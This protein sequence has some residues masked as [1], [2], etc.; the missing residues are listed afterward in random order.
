MASLTTRISDMLTAVSTSVRALRTL[1][2]GSATGNLT[3]LTTTDKTSIIAAINEVKAG[4]GGGASN[5]D[6]LT[7]VVI[8]SAATGDILRFNG[9]NWV[10]VD[11]STIFDLVGAAAAAQAASQPLDADL[12]AIAALTT[13]TYGRAILALANQAALMA[14][15]SNG[16]SGAPGI[17]QLASTAQVQTGTDTAL[18]TTSAGVKA[19]IDQRIDN[20][21]SLGASTTNAPSQAAVKAYA[22]ALIAANDAFTAKGGINASANPNFPA[23][24][25]GDTY[26]ITNAGKIGGASGDNVEVGDLVQCWVDGSAAGTKATVGANWSIIQVNIDGAV[27]GPASSV[28]ANLAAFNGTSGKAVQD[29]GFSP[30]NAAIGAGSATILPTSA[31]I[32]AFSQPKDAT[33]TALAA[34]VTATDTLI[35]ATGVDTFATTAFTAFAR[36]LLDDVDA[37]TMRGTLSVY[38]QA[39]IGT[40]DTDFATAY[41]TA[42]NA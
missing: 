30:S 26:R 34:V 38:S 5:L 29:S 15:L 28:S 8:T 1:V 12:T 40:P 10:D 37:T 39:E 33:L 17:L 18:A 22:D 24:N 6:A 36:T 42:L 32:V 7:D 25:A 27:T 35:Y 20:N 21:S 9:T 13:T 16:T 2:T 3:T 4:G 19:A 23:A 31:Q 11:G 14:L 41:N